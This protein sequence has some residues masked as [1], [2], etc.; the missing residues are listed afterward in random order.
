[1]AEP[2]RPMLPLHEMRKL[3]T[4]AVAV[5]HGAARLLRRAA[6]LVDRLAHAFRRACRARDHDR[7]QLRPVPETLLEETQSVSTDETVRRLPHP[8]QSGERHAQVRVVE[9]IAVRLPILGTKARTRRPALGD[10]VT[11][12]PFL[13]RL[14]LRERGATCAARHR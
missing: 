11:P 12:V 4:D 9:L 8:R 13:L 6:D 3:P 5:L 7:V 10:R 14:R 2:L 1:D